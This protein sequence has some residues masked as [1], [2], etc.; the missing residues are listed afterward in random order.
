MNGKQIG[1]II[2]LI[3]L[4]PTLI[5]IFAWAIKN[6]NDPGNPKNLEVGVEM[7]ANSAIPWWLGILDWLAGLPG[8]I[9]ALLV[10][11]FIIFLKWTGEIK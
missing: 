2:A 8:L 7:I 4:I 11:G 1:T 10:I 9:G 3:V 5:G 6:A